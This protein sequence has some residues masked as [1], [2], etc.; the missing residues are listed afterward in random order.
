MLCRMRRREPT[1][2]HRARG[3]LVAAV[4]LAALAAA[5][6]GGS[7][8][9]EVRSK[10]RRAPIDRSTTAATVLSNSQ[11]ATDLYR[12]L[13]RRGG[14]FVFSPYT[15]SLALAEVAAGARGVTA[16]QLAGTQ[17]QQPGQDLP[18]GLNTL[19]QQ[20][21]SRA[22]DR[23][24]TVRQGQVSIDVP[25]SLWGQLDTLVEQPFL[26]ELAR[27]YGTGIRLVDFRSDPG[28]ARTQVNN[29]MAQESSSQF[30]AVVPPGHVT[31]A[32][33]LLMTAGAFIAAPW[34]QRFDASRTRQT[35]FHLLDG[36][37][38][39]V[40]TMS[41]SSPEGLLYASG[42]GWQAVMLPF[43]GRQL[44]MV[45]VVPDAGRF[46]AVESQ[47]DG[48]RF[49]SVLEAVQPLPID[50]EMP[51]FQFST[52]LTLD[53]LLRAGGLTSLFDPATSQLPGIT[54]DEA[55]WVDHFEDDA[56]I[57]ADEE[58]MEASAPTAVRPAP[59]MPAARTTLRIDRPFV[60]AVVDRASGEPLLFGRI[61]D[62]TAS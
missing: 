30:D 10:V 56:F 52:R 18:S 59:P 40:T 5:C 7:T 41:I 37:T 49:Q 51:R 21:A 47:L 4:V 43:L 57:S 45:L 38:T 44:A 33:R 25:V 11:L 35:T 54:G 29:W 42:D 53:P 9:T 55:L 20:I 61:V 15:I 46:H 13:A 58:G 2:R 28:S 17:H 31:E 6:A 26:D 60:V 27:W 32:T 24:N 1:A 16:L 22:G 39:D 3:A 48:A 8:G 12:A 23:Q 62:P 34:D 50:L 36:S 14:N 19:G